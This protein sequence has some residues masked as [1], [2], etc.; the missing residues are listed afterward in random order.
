MS[1]EVPEV[2]QRIKKRVKKDCLTSRTQLPLDGIHYTALCGDRTVL[3]VSTL[4]LSP[5][6]RNSRNALS[7]SKDAR[8]LQT[9]MVV[10]LRHVKIL[11]YLKNDCTIF[12]E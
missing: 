5:S 6:F 1:L 4:K 2:Y 3:L 12:H 11:R 9:C 7:L 8:A 10:L